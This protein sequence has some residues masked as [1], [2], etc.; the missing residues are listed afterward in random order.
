MSVDDTDQD[1]ATRLAAAFKTFDMRSLADLTLDERAI[2]VFIRELLSEYIDTS[3]GRQSD[4]PPGES[5][6]VAGMR[7]LTGALLANAKEAQTVA[8]DD[9]GR[10]KV[11]LTIE[12]LNQDGPA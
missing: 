3:T 6:A 1:H 2:Q 8:G 10:I 5:A 7:H 11:G 4:V 9:L 12:I